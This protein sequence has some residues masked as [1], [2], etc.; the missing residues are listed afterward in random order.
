MSG[1]AVVVPYTPHCHFRR[2]LIY[3]GSTTAVQGY[4]ESQGFV[5]PP[6]TDLPS[7]M[8]ELTSAAGR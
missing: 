4:F 7:W 2:H 8:V 3:S 1:I 6:R 5:L